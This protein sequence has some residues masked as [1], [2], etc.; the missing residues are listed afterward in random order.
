MGR[1]LT[2][3]SSHAASKLQQ[4]FSVA[5]LAVPA[6]G[7]VV[8]DPLMGVIDTACIGRTS[9]EQLAALAP[10]SAVFNMLFQ[11]F[12]FI[13]VSVT[14]VLAVHSPGVPGISDSERRL[15]IQT[16]K[17]LQSSALVAAAACGG[18]CTLVC[19]L[20]GPNVLRLMGV[21]EELLP[22]ALTYL[23]TRSLGAPAVMLMNASQGVFLA[24]QDTMTPLTIF[25]CSASFNTLLCVSL[26]IGARLGMY[27]AAL[28]T[29]CVQTCTAV[30]FLKALE[31]RGS[32]EGG[33]PLVWEG[34]P[35]ARDIKAFAD[36]AW[37][38]FSRTL[39][40]MTAFASITSVAMRLPLPAAAIHQI[41]L[42]LFWLL[43]FFPEP[44]SMSAQ[45]IIAR[46]AADINQVTQ[47]SWL[48]LRLAGFLSIG[49]AALVATCFLFGS[50]VF[51]ADEE[52]INGVHDLVLPAMA[53]IVACTYTMQCDGIFI[54]S[55]DFAHLPRTNLLAAIFTVSLL[56]VG[57]SR[58]Y[59]LVWVWWVMAFF[60]TARLVQHALHAVAHFETS[61]FGLYRRPLAVE[62]HAK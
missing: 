21:G 53:G 11:V 33:V 15:R 24:Q 34:W 59:G 26:V 36:V 58:G 20:Y 40:K 43:S 28:A 45:S 1:N 3:S 57:E 8:V 16:S 17:K 37:K 51:T 22:V 9:N 31:V 44:L 49:L 10:N 56:W 29:C 60:F 62:R 39:F 55:L 47:M 6:L 48:L 12:T 35:A 25:L 38:L 50:Y 19:Q 14:N 5:A 18:L 61:A 52:I 32:K 30:A 42:Q 41:A 46:N 4:L 13:G 2:S 27:G 23:R 54:G 7:I